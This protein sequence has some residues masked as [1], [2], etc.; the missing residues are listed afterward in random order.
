MK[1]IKLT[2]HGRVQG[3]GFRWHAQRLAE[4]HGVKGYVQNRSDGTVEIVGQGRE[5]PSFVEAVRQGPSHAHI[6]TVEE[7]ATDEE[8]YP[9]F[10]IHH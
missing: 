5:L 9:D 10:S 3:I 8:E 2:L 1:T 7:T 4:R 6:E